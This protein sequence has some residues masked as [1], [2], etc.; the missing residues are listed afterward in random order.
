MNGNVKAIGKSYK[1][2]IIVH[3]I[4]LLVPLVLL[5]IKP[6][7]GTLRITSM[8]NGPPAIG[9]YYLITIPI[10]VVLSWSAGKK[11][12]HQVMKRYFYGFR[13]FA[14]LGW[15]AILAMTVVFTVLYS[16]V[17]SLGN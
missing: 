3:S 9:A 15:V 10:L 1:W 2:L 5:L 17:N 16:R 7:I 8:K 4:I 14:T 13:I 12:G 11:C 6:E